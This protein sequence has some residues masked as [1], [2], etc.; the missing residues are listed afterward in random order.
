MNRLL[1]LASLCALLGACT[2]ASSAADM[3]PD[4]SV[5]A[6]MTAPD[7]AMEVRIQLKGTV[8]SLH[9]TPVQG[10]TVGVLDDTGPTATS[11]ATGAYTLQVPIGHVVTLYATATGYA[12]TIEQEIEFIHPTTG[13]YLPLAPQPDFDALQA[14]DGN[15]AN[16]GVI[17][18]VASGLSNC[19]PVGGT[20]GSTPPTGKVIYTGAP[21]GGLGAIP[22]PSLTSIQSGALIQAFIVGATERVSPTLQAPG[23]RAAP[24]PISVQQNYKIAGPI[25]VQAGSYHDAQV[26][27]Q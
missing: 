15:V 12:R 19:T 1:L 26:F 11:D 23:C 13:F 16:S 22:D 25:D 18:L 17:G 24:Y 4:Q 8:L 3:S 5:A 27:T 7:L 20:V 10:A 6:D 14:L 2:D 9:G 21:D